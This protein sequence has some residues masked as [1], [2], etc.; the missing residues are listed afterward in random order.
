MELIRSPWADIFETFGRSIRHEAIL[1]APFIAKEPLDRLASILDTSNHP[2]IELLTN[3]AVDSLLYGSV[4][5]QGIASFC[6]Q[7]PETTV[8]HLPGLHAKAYVAD[9][10]LAIITSGNLTQASLHHNYE[11][12]I[13]INDSHLVR[14]IS[15]DLR[16]YGALGSRVSIGELDQL[17]EIADTLRARHNETLRTAR[18]TVRKEFERQIEVAHDALRYLRAKPGESTSSIFSRTIL[19]VLGNGPLTTEQIHP[20]VEAIHPDLCDNAVDRVINTVHFGKR[21]K[22][23]VRSAQQ[24]LK[25]K[26]LVKYSQN[27]WSLAQENSAGS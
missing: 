8:R 2:K 19:Y 24:R 1:V 7:H 27:K 4:D 12:G 17:A 5:A 13:Q 18:V 10:H 23:W 16:D 14:Q 25:A 9:E 20:L 3:L 15:R 6:R 21:W 11:Y 22:H 26:G